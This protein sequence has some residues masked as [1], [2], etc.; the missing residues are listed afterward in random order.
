[1]T[2][3]GQ[4]TSVME[5]IFSQISWITLTLFLSL[6][7]F[8]GAPTESS[9]QKNLMTGTTTATV[10]NVIDG[11]TIDVRVEGQSDSIRVR[12]IGID[13]PEPYAHE[14][15]ECGSFE[16]TQRNKELVAGKNITLVSGVK[17]YDAYGRLLAYIY[18][19]NTFVNESLVADGYATVLM[20]RPNTL[21]QKEFLD[22]YQ[23]AKEQKR[24]IWSICT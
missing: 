7:T 4:S 12:Y 16:A 17:Q 9:I 1:M 23:T 3:Y 10:T 2:Y 6:A 15:P 20:I 8:F 11:D 18:V 24:G 21:Y 19:G 13:T 5:Y 14:I 22:L